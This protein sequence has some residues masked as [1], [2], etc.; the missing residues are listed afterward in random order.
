MSERSS[1]AGLKAANLVDLPGAAD[2][3]PDLARVVTVVLDGVAAFNGQVMGYVQSAL[4]AQAEAAEELRR[5]ESPNA[6]AEVQMRYA[7]RAVETYFDELSVLGGLVTRVS[8]EAA[9]AL[10]PSRSA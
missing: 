3:A 7:R 8:K 2:A 9:E 5:C 6:W 4:Q 10:A 1:K